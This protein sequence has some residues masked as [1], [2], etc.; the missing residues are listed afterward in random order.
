MAR[1]LEHIDAQAA[2]SLLGGNGI[3]T[4]LCMRSGQAQYLECHLQRLYAQM[5]LLGLGRD[6]VY[7]FLKSQSEQM[8][9]AM[10]PLAAAMPLARLKIVL[11]LPGEPSTAA[12]QLKMLACLQSY[13]ALEKAEFALATCS[14]TRDA[15]YMGNSIKSLSYQPNLLAL[16]QA[17]AAGADEALCLNHQGEICEGSFSNIFW[18]QGHRLFTP[19]PACGLLQGVMRAQVMKLAATHRLELCEGRY[20]REQLPQAEAVFITTCLRGMQRVTRVDNSRFEQAW[21]QSLLDMQARLRP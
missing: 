15:G 6:G 17:K 7:A 19:E 2:A 4:T 13:S 11:L 9:A 12:A 16:Q 18:L 14:W 1:S 20:R 21:P 8:L 5:R 10:A 3:F